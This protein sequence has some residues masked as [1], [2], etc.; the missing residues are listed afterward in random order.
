MTQEAIPLVDA[1]SPDFF[2]HFSA[3]GALPRIPTAERHDYEGHVYVLRF[4]EVVKVGTTTDPGARIA[5][6]A[7]SHLSKHGAIDRI[8]VSVPHIDAEATE[9]ALIDFCQANG[10]VIP[11]S[12]E[13]FT[14][15]DIRNVV[16]FA[17]SLPYRRVDV[18]EWL[19]RVSALREEQRQYTERTGFAASV[20]DFFDPNFVCVRRDVW[21]EVNALANRS[22][23]RMFG[24]VGGEYRIPEIQ[25]GMVVDE[26]IMSL[27]DL[28]KSDAQA[29]LDMDYIDLLEDTAMNMVRSE[30]LNLRAFAIENDRQDMLTKVG[31]A[32]LTG[33]DGPAS[34]PRGDE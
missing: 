23:A 31:A 6:H 29:I 33:V 9:R 14:G 18:A 22:P 26:L 3:P 13:S 16:D 25:A 10:V 32:W 7:K 21:N 5:R 28:R 12:S 27:A 1:G 17:R 8:W 11:G 30:A 19:R 34:G 2:D 24:R 4:G 20:G 15:L